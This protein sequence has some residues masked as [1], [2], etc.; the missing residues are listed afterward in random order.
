MPVKEIIKMPIYVIDASGVKNNGGVTVKNCGC[1][2]TLD[3]P[4]VG[5]DPL[6]GTCVILGPSGRNDPCQFVCFPSG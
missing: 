6:D 4:R 5:T 2:Q 1:E 3:W